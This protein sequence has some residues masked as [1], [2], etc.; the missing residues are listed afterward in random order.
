[1]KKENIGWIDLLRVVACFLVVFSH[2]CDPFVAQ[3]DNDRTS[4][5]TGVFSGSLV[6]PC[7]PLFVM[8]TGVL[9]L[10]VRTG[11]S[12]FY[13]RRIG[14]VLVPLAFWSIALPVAFHL[15]LNYGFRKTSFVAQS[16]TGF[17]RKPLSLPD[18]T[19]NAPRRTESR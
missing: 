19:E 11:M 5:L 8:M 7:V 2:C 12:E 13:R 3:F 9:L 18:R 10:P 6:R 17:G 4:F 16:A 15:Y 14:R 1:M